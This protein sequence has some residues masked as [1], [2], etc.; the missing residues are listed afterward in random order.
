MNSYTKNST[1]KPQDERLRQNLEEIDQKIEQ[2]NAI[3][4]ALSDLVKSC[5]SDSPTS[6]FPILDAF[7][8]GLNAES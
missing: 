4:M 6:D 2:L 7:E 3:K 5:N 8:R 1:Q